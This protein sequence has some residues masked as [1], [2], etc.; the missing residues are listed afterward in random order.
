MKAALRATALLSGSSLITIAAGVINSKV[1]AE[2]LGTGGVALAAILTTILAFVLIPST[3]GIGPAVVR[4]IASAEGAGDFGRS[5][6]VRHAAWRVRVVAIL[7]VSVVLLLGRDPISRVLL[8]G[9]SGIEDLTMVIAA[10]ALTMITELQTSILNGY[11]RVSAMAKIATMS[12]VLGTVVTVVLTATLK[13][14]GVAPAILAGAAVGV[15]LSTLYFR[16]ELRVHCESGASG[17][18]FTE[19]N[20]LLRF[21]LP[22]TLSAVVGTG[23]TTV[24]PILVLHELGPQAVA[25]YQAAFVIAISYLGFL[26]TAMGQDYFPRVSASRNDPKRLNSLIQQQI[27]LVLIVAVPV[28]LATSSLAPYLVSAAYTSAF[29]PA[30]ATLQWQL[31]ADLFK[32]VSWTLAFAIVARRGGYLYL[33]T[34]CVGGSLLLITTFLGSRVFG[35]PGIGAGFLAT[36]VVYTVV[37]WYVVRRDTGF[38]LSVQNGWHL[39][40]ATSALAVTQLANALLAPGLRLLVCLGLTVAALAWSLRMV[41]SE[42]AWTWKRP[43]SRGR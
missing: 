31:F 11:H 15:C 24:I 27:T 41:K 1:R 6:V 3:L 9:A 4:E 21:G 19:V 26:I 37:V 7:L 40:M 25:Y 33:F 34:E 16:N 39:A 32:F 10:L 17:S 22:Y 5:V 28:I 30:T 23:S 43:I 18:T 36:Y 12:A 13:L 8:N 42:L 20:V 38:R 29:R 2:L 35:L 14:R